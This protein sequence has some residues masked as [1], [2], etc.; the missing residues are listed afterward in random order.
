MAEVNKCM[1][2]SNLKKNRILNNNPLITNS[3]FLKL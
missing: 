3:N 2:D 1:L